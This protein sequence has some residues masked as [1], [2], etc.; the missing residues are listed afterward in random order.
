M[1]AHHILADWVGDAAAGDV[2]SGTVHGFEEAGEAAFRVD[3]RARCD[4]DG[5]GAG[6]AE[7]G[8]NVAEQVAGHDDVEPVGVHHEVRG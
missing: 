7:V 5:A 4:A 6:G 8:E 3:V 1:L 2:R